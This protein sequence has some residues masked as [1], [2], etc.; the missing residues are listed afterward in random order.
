MKSIILAALAASTIYAQSDYK[1][2][3][4]ITDPSERL[5]I[6]DMFADGEKLNEKAQEINTSIAATALGKE[7][8]ELIKQ[9]NDLQDKIT[10]L[11]AKISDTALGKELGEISTQ[12]DA[13][14]KT[15][16]EATTPIL[17]AHGCVG[18]VIAQS[19]ELKGCPA[20][21]PV[22]VPATSSK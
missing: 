5:K 11:N 3:T 8:A 13:L 21:S 12:M 10:K 1:K 2:P 7:R 14:R 22:A 4:P 9:S 19:L 17:A 6:F 20:P 15:F 16:S 18:G